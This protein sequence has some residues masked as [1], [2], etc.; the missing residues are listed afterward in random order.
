MA[1][2]LDLVTQKR[3]RFVETIQGSGSRNRSAVIEY[4]VETISRIPVYHL[5]LLHIVCF[6]HFIGVP[7]FGIVERGRDIQI[8]EQRESRTH[9]NLVLHG[10]PPVL[11]QARLEQFVFFRIDTVTQVT[12]VTHGNLFIP[13]FFAD[14]TFPLEREDTAHRNRNI[15]QSQR[16]RR[17]FRTLV[18]VHGSRKAERIIRETLRYTDTGPLGILVRIR[19]PLRTRIETVQ[20]VTVV[21]AGRKV[22][23]CREGPVRIGFRVLR[24]C[25][26]QLEVLRQTIV[27]KPL[28]AQAGNQVGSIEAARKLIPLPV[29]RTGRQSPGTFRIDFT[30]QS[31]IHIIAQRKIIPSVAQVETTR[32]FIPESRHDN[33]RR[34]RT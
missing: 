21:A 12:V 4:T 6:F 14:R 17:V 3:Q 25:P 7:T 11:H 34:I 13:T 23:T 27:G 20:V 33:T 18:H 9:R 2:H 26:V 28:V 1:D 5:L 10:I 29:R 8:L 24:M 31:Q 19:K 16:N 15:G 30:C 32:T 22:H